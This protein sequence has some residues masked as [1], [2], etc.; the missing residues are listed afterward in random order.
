MK[1]G[2]EW[3]CTVC[4]HTFRTCGTQPFYRNEKNERKPHGYPEP[5]SEEAANAGIKGFWVEWYCPECKCAQDA[6]LI[7]YEAHRKDRTAWSGIRDKHT[8]QQP[9]CPKC[10][11][12][13]KVFLD[14]EDICPKCD[15]G[16]FEISCFWGGGNR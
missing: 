4:G 7:E 5:L 8:R 2:I 16:T 9:V 1:R 15:K 13:L 3:K 10:G 11:T 14:E 6:V 12:N